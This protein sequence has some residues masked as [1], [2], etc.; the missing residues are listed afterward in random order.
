MLYEALKDDTFENVAANTV[1]MSSF[2]VS[3][4][5]WEAPIFFDKLEG[6]DIPP[7]L[8][9]GIYGEFAEAL[10]IATETPPALSV[11]MVLGVLSASA[12]KHFRVTPKQGWREPLNIYT[13]VALPPANNKSQI[14]NACTKPLVQWEQEK[15]EILR[16][17]IKRQQSER[18]TQEK[19]IAELRAQAARTKNR[20]EQEALV[21]EI[22]D[23]EAELIEPQIL[24]QVFANDITP[25][26]LTNAIFE[27]KGNF[28]IFSD[29]GGVFEVLAGL[30][31]GG[32][33][34]IDV[35]LKGIDGGHVRV[36]RKDR[37]VDLNPYL[38]IGLVVQ[39]S[40][41]QKMSSKNAFC[42]NGVLERFLYVLPKS[43]LGYRTHNTASVP[44]YLSQIYEQKVKSLLNYSL[45]NQQQHILSLSPDAFAAWQAFQ[46]YI[47]TELRPRGKLSGCQGWGGKICGFTLRIA[48]LMHIAKGELNVSIIDKE[49]MMNALDLA[50]LLIQHTLA[51]YGLMGS[52]QEMEDAKE[53]L[54]WIL[55]SNSESFTRTQITTAMKHKGAGKSKRL[56][57]ALS[58]LI[59]RN[60]IYAHKDFS[61]VKPTMHYFTNPVLQIKSGKYEP[62]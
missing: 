29:E 47:E 40:I 43:K 30:Y 45:D 5:K 25:E 46:L 49:T 17:I 10:C 60:F 4:I 31:T 37:S 35:L 52:D 15:A 14:L 61:T 16:P 36:K 33:A 32:T 7:S 51:A 58:I 48:G 53:V 8:L 6:P 34:N 27:Q 26:S 1:S 62:V 50:A 55:K 22:S 11:M 39:P 41:I 44:Q 12:A 3:E 21:R 2:N 57:E 9:P 13:I 23:I 56:G 24:P 38:T 42:G 19:I 54:N 18:K 20:I 59:D 28:A